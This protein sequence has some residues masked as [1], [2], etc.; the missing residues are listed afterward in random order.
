[1]QPTLR[2]IYFYQQIQAVA[3]PAYRWFYMKANNVKKQHCW[4]DL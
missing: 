3:L 2:K 4:T 1:M